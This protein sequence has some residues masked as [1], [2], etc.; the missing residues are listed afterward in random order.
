MRYLGISV[1][2][3]A[4]F[5]MVLH[6]A[7]LAQ[8]PTIGSGTSRPGTLPST[9]P[10]QNL[11]STTGV[12][13]NQQTLDKPVNQP[14]TIQSNR[15]SSQPSD[16]PAGTVATSQQGGGGIGTGRRSRVKNSDTPGSGVIGRGEFSHPAALERQ[17]PKIP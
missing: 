11:R 4:L 1:I 13:Q 16:V 5:G 7:V 17:M 2:G 8:T 9:A 14:S 3:V 12:I 6:G 10:A 15:P